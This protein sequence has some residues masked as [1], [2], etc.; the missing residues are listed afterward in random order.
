MPETRTI[1]PLGGRDVRAMMLGGLRR[2]EQGVK[3]KT[4]RTRMAKV[5]KGQGIVYIISTMFGCT[6][7]MV[8][9]LR[10][11]RECEIK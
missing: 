10:V 1:L 4:K 6:I 8:T 3:K 2:I 11:Y 7:V 9:G 5:Q